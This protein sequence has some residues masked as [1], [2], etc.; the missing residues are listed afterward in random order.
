MKVFLFG[1]F[2]T[3]EMSQSFKPIWIWVSI[4]TEQAIGEKDK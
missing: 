4:S 2:N 3:V 1:T